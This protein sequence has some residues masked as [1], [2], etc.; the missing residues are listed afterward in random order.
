MLCFAH[1]GVYLVHAVS[2]RWQTRE[3]Y[4]PTIPRRT[5]MKSNIAYNEENYQYFLYKGSLSVTECSS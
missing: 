4:F 5:I 3:T 2:C 1:I